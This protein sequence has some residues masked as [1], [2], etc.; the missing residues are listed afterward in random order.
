M[1]RR[2]IF[3][4][5]LISLLLIGSFSQVLAAQ[6]NANI[7]PQT[8]V[9]TTSYKFLRTVFI[10]YEG[11]GEVADV[12]RGQTITMK[13][14]ADSGTPGVSELIDKI[15]TNLA[16]VQSNVVVTDLTLDYSV[17]LIGRGL[18]AS[19]DYKLFLNPVISD[20]I[21]REQT[22][23]T[24]AWVD[25]NWRGL[26]VEGP[27]II[28]TV[29]FG[30]VDINMP[31]SFI[32]KK[33]PEVYAKIAGSEAEELLN[34]SL[35]DASGIKAQPLSNWHF[36]FDPTGIGSDAAT[37]GLSEEISGFVIS[38][39]TMGESSLREGIQIE[40]ENEAVFTADKSYTV[41]TVESA[42]AANIALIGFASPDKI[43]TLDIFGVSPNPP[44]G[45]ATTSSGEFPV[46]IIYGMAAMGAIG[47]VAFLFF[48]N[49]ML[50][51]EAALG[52]QQQGI[53]P[54]RLTA[55]ATSGQY[56]TT[57]GEAVLKEEPS[58]SQGSP[59]VSDQL[60]KQKGTLPKGY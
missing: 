36:L 50:K 49:K 23:A 7:N 29:G 42:D 4:T 28:S 45:Y 21:I 15:N 41:R 54:S 20:F 14:S 18:S 51:K 8:G 32:E 1:L 3:A 17:I 55:Q 56:Q 31:I 35:I 43:E 46:Q 26:S 52:G 59:D 10:E 44:E 27:A 53:D 40:K 16:G 38:T 37:F 60:K 48:S 2:L 5:V 13:F 12:L 11:G 9:A 24:P 57:R 39:F 25:A 19:I 33:V 47:A 6:L 22:I 58:T 34:E 30:D